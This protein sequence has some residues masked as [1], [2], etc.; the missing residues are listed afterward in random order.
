VVTAVAAA[1]EVGREA[2]RDARAITPR[3]SHRDWEPQADRRDPVEVLDEE[4]TQRIDELVPIRH[5]RM[6]KSPFAFFRGA[7]GIM[8]GD[9]AGTPVSGFRVQLCGD[10]HLANFGGFGSPE[11]TLLFDLNDFDETLPGPWEWDL[12]RLAAS[13]A[14]ALREHGAGAGP[15]RDIVGH[16]VAH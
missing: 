14:I 10:A 12:K 5:A 7:A 9:L 1:A 16:P 8:A 6:A 2:G 4:S 13:I 11:R 3:S 15:P